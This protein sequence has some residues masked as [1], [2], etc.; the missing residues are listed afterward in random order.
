MVNLY[1]C[2]RPILYEAATNG[3]TLNDRRGQWPLTP[4]K[5]IFIQKWYELVARGIGENK[6]LNQF[7]QWF[8][9]AHSYVVQTFDRLTS[10]EIKENSWKYKMTRLNYPLPLLPE[11]ETILGS[12]STT[13]DSIRVSES[14]NTHRS[15]LFSAV[16]DVRII[17]ETPAGVTITYP[18][19]YQSARYYWRTDKHIATQQPNTFVYRSELESLDDSIATISPQIAS[20]ADVD[21]EPSGNR[22]VLTIEHKHKSIFSQELEL[23]TKDLP[24]RRTRITIDRRMIEAQD[25]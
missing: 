16:A 17:P 6:S 21:D 5:R 15:R 12:S 25:D 23:K 14:E 20:D 10:Q 24:R 22:G 1:F 9:L 19:N 4:T 8:N 11:E 7:E 2:L 18:N 3:R 13:N